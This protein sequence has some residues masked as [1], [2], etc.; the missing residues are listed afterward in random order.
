MCHGDAGVIRSHGIRRTWR[1]SLLWPHGIAW[2]VFGDHAARSGVFVLFRAVVR[3]VQFSDGSAAAAMPP[4]QLPDN[5][6][7]PRAPGQ[8]GYAQ[9][10]QPGTAQPATYA[11]AAAPPAQAP[12][13]EQGATVG[14]FKSSYVNFLQAFRDPPEPDP[15]ASP[16]YD[17]R[18]SIYPQRPLT[19]RSKARAIEPT[20]RSER[21]RIPPAIACGLVE[22][23]KSA[24]T[25][26]VCSAPA[27]HLQPIGA[28]LYAAGAARLRSSAG[29]AEL[30]GTFGSAGLCSATRSAKLRGAAGSTSLQRARSRCRACRPV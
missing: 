4:S 9:Q 25:A 22:Q 8:P 16:G 24:A 13:S 28:T 11:A 20:S 18:A 27:E 19:T 14:S 10:A 15:S 26:R 23:R 12:A 17:A 7:T 5:R 3:L 2:G 21:R 1:G 6:N 29:P 30:R